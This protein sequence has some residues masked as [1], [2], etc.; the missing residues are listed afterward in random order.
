MGF[1]SKILSW[2]TLNG[3]T[4]L[5]VIQV[6]IKFLKEILTGIVNILF[7][8]IPSE[9]FQSVVNKVREIVN[10]V[11]SVVQKIKDW[12]IGVAK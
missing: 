7:P 6:G 12:L 10:K 8:I 5:A 1:I 2:I 9:K 11:D 3:V 4:V